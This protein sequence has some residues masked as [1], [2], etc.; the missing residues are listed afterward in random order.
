MLWI[1][2]TIEMTNFNLYRVGLE[3]AQKNNITCRVLR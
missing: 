2:Q 3:M 1:E